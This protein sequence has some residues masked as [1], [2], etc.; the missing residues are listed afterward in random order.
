MIG[1]L[2]VFRIV[3][4]IEWHENADESGSRVAPA[5]VP[6]AAA[7]SQYVAGQATLQ[8]VLSGEAEQM[9]EKL[10]TQ[11]EAARELGIT[12]QAVEWAIRHDKIGHVKVS[13]PVVMI[14]ASALRAYA[15]ARASRSS[16]S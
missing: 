8:E 11:S 6:G 13:R 3:F 12:R 4:A 10:L 15:K 14:P 16:I 7:G 2:P 5:H 1:R 9:S